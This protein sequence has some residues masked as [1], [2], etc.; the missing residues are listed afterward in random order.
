M[1]FDQ[2]V[3][4]KT[5]T[6][7]KTE[8]TSITS[9]RFKSFLQNM[10]FQRDGIQL[11]WRQTQLRKYQSIQGQVQFKNHPQSQITRSAGGWCLNV[12]HTS[13]FRV[14]LTGVRGANQC[15]KTG[16]MREKPKIYN[17]IC[18]QKQY[19]TSSSV[20]QPRFPLISDLTHLLI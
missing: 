17:E 2:C 10:I 4:H 14:L 13:A 7:I 15:S 20:F 16:K 8:N 12:C 18:S 1:S 19:G 3:I 9:G 6:S 11:K 5:K